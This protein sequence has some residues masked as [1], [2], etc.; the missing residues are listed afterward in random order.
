MVD[1]PSL[2]KLKHS[3]GSVVFVSL[4]Y[5][6][7]IIYVH[8]IFTVVS[9]EVDHD[10]GKMRED[11]LQIETIKRDIVHHLIEISIMTIMMIRN[12]REEVGLGHLSIGQSRREVGQG[13]QMMS[14]VKL[15]AIRDLMAFLLL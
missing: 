14:Q 10:T 7:I 9:L 5:S 6:H 3:V 8:L 1:K 11:A 4:T 13:H 2:N 12:I 15:V